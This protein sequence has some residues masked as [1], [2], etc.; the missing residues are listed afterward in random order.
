[1]PKMSAGL[2]VY[3]QR[4]GETEIFLVHPGGPFWAKKD[5]GAWSIPKGEVG[6]G[7]DALAA[8][9]REFH[10]ETNVSVSGEYTPLDAVKQPSGKIIH[11]WATQADFD[12]GAIRSNTFSIEWP[13]G[14]GVVREYPEVDRAAW[15]G[16]ES[17]RQKVI[18]GQIPIIDQLAQLLGHRATPTPDPALRQGSLF[19][20]AL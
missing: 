15:F 7:E 3:R 6:E 5:E 11:A 16:L 17:A 12:A 13:R 1:M 19:D 9:I 20:E 10:E 18:K 2:L 4:C 8:A 14:S